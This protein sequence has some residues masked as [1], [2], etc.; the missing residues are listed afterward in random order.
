MSDV[1]TAALLGSFRV[2]PAEPVEAGSRVTLTIEYTVGEAGIA[3]GGGLA[4]EFPE[5]W[6][7]PVAPR[8]SLVPW[9]PKPSSDVQPQVVPYSPRNISVTV[10]SAAAAALALASEQNWARVTVKGA[11]LAKGDTLTLVYGDKTWGSDGALVSNCPRN[12]QGIG[13]FVDAKG[14]GEFAPAPGSPCLIEVVSGETSQ[15]LVVGPSLTEPGTPVEIKLA[16]LDRSHNPPRS[17]FISRVIGKPR[18]DSP[19]CGVR[20]VA[21]ETGTKKFVRK[22]K[23]DTLFTE[24]FFEGDTSSKIIVSPATLEPGVLRVAVTDETGEIFGMSNPVESADPQVNYRIFWGDLHGRTAA[25]SRARKVTCDE[26]YAFARKHALLDFAAV[27]DENGGFLDSWKETQEAAARNTEN[28]KFVALK[29]F[30]W[31]SPEFGHRAVYFKDCAVDP[32]LPGGATEAAR[33]PIDNLY[34]LFKGREVFMVPFHPF[35]L[36]NWGRLNPELEPLTEIYSGMGAA[37]RHKNPLWF[38]SESP[39]G[40]VQAALA[41]GY[42]L[43]FIACSHTNIGCPGRG[44]AEMHDWLP[45]KGGLTAV[46]AKEL[47]REAIFDALK[48]RRCYAT[49]GARIILKVSVNKQPMGSIIEIPKEKAGQP[50]NLHISAIGTDVISKIEVVCN[51][52]DAFLFEPNRDHTD[53]MYDDDLPFDEVLAESK[54][55]GLDLKE[56]FYYVRVTQRDGEIAWSSPIWVKL[57]E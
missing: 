41:R 29:C 25:S 55:R 2:A 17:P 43:G 8:L 9:A 11:A 30:E 56:I 18:A 24:T 35:V 16:A 48:A 5:T 6:E 51:N 23:L 1:Q 3:V 39:G 19:S 4:I 38:H 22:K 49:T 13:L 40:G 32:T 31:N 57:K 20:V 28:G 42:H 12:D 34:A 36:M 44:F 15:F 54:E 21:R 45:V 26:F 14:S 46:C 53:Y 47:T 27:G 50:R 37:E 10:K 7:K 33:M 52:D